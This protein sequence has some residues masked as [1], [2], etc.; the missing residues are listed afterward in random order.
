MGG[1]VV[2]VISGVGK[3]TNRKIGRGSGLFGQG[4]PRSTILRCTH[5]PDRLRRPLK[6]RNFITALYCRDSCCPLG[7]PPSL[8]FAA[9]N[10]VCYISWRDKALTRHLHCMARKTASLYK[11]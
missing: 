7:T 3:R 5:G 9:P 10:P 4:G 11:T 2:S 1:K 6:S 8:F